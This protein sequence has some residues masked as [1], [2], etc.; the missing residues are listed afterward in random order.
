M[1]R[2]DL[3]FFHHQRDHLH[4]VLELPHISSPWMHA[5]DL[6][7]RRREALLSLSVPLGVAG[8]E[9]I[10]QQWD[11]IQ[12]LAKWRDA[13]RH[14]IDAIEQILAE[15]T[16]GDELLQILIGRGDEADVHGDGAPAAEALDFAALKRA[17]QLGLHGER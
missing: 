12:P 16:A 14:G 13:Q 4:E 5:E 10:D 3:L 17:K 8:G 7:R 6:Q 2:S 9:E 11:V 1:R 15:R